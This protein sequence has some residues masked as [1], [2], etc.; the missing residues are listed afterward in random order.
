MIEMCNYYDLI[1]TSY[2]TYETKQKT[3]AQLHG[4]LKWM[5]CVGALKLATGM[6][7]V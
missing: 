1:E 6:E 4:L 5:N 7:Y 2:S 3:P